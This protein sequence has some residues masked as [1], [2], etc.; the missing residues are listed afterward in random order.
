[1]YNIWLVS[2]WMCL[3]MSLQSVNQMPRC[4]SQWWGAPL[5]HHTPA[6]GLSPGWPC[7]PCTCKLRLPHKFRRDWNTQPRDL[8]SPDNLNYR[9]IIYYV[10]PL[11]VF[12]GKLV[13]PAKL[14]VTVFAENIP[15][16]NNAFSCLPAKQL[17]W[18]STLA[19][20]LVLQDHWS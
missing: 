6:P 2:V 10:P 15:G 9:N 8:N 20:F 14:G 11:I 16:A 18:M 1:M 13:H 17:W 7:P 4:P 19:P 3:Q 5:S 12:S